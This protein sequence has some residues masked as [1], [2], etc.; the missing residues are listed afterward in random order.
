MEA[1]GV[2]PWFQFEFAGLHTNKL[3]PNDPL[4]SDQFHLNGEA[5][6]DINAVESWDINRGAGCSGEFIDEGAEYT[7]PD[8]IGA[9]R[10]DLHFDFVSGDN[11]PIPETSFENPTERPLPAVL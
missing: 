1:D 9:S 8:L 10:E 6:S 4:F 2:I 5:Q 11:D 7:H 3:V